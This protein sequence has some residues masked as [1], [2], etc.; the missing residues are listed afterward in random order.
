MK[1]RAEGQFGQSEQIEESMDKKGNEG[2]SGQRTKE[3][4]HSPSVVS[5]PHVL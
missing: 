1:E 3:P 2:H 4:R 5:I